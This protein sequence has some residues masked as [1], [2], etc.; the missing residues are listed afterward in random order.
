M[1]LVIEFF[2][3]IAITHLWPVTAKWPATSTPSQSPVTTALCGISPRSVSAVAWVL[4]TEIGKL[5][6]GHS[7]LI[8]A[9]VG[10]TQESD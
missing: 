8:E 3:L 7:D 10:I 9:V 5:A 2:V 1:Y 6:S 4:L